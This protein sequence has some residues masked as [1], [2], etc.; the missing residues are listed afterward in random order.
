MTR[1]MGLSVPLIHSI[2]RGRTGHRGRREY[3]EKAEGITSKFQS[4]LVSNNLKFLTMF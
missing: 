4:R 1:L 2:K 3:T